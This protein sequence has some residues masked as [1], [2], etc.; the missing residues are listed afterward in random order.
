MTLTPDFYDD[1]VQV[2]LPLWAQSH[3][4]RPTLPDLVREVGAE[5]V[6][7]EANAFMADIDAALVEDSGNLTYIRTP[8]WMISGEVLKYRNGFLAVCRA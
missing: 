4:A 1:L 2:L 5:S 8:N 6:D 3:R 7:P